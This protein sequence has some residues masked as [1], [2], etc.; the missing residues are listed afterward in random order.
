ML[1]VSQMRSNRFRILDWCWDVEYS[2]IFQ[3]MLRFHGFLKTRENGIVPSDCHKKSTKLRF[4]QSF[5]I[6]AKEALMRLALR[7]RSKF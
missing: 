7:S 3:V 6:K 1:R 4:G 5:S 2:S